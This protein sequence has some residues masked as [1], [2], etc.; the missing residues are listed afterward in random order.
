MVPLSDI[1]TSNA[2]LKSL[3][4]GLVAVFVGGTSGIGL[5]TARELVRNTTSPHIYLVGRNQDEASKI[6]QELKS[7]NASSQVDF[8]QKDVSLLKN[9][10]EVCKEILSK[11]KH[12][13]LL[14]MTCGYYTLKGRED[15]TEGL[16]RKFALHYYARARFINQLQ[17]LL[18]TA[19]AS[20]TLSRVVAV[21]DPQ[22]GLRMSM[23]FSDLSLKSHF[24]L[25]NCAV[26]AGTMTNLL[27]S[28][29]AS[30]NSGT[31]YVHAF[32]YVVDT[33]VGRDA[34]GPLASVMKPLLKVVLKP[35]T[36]EQKESGERHLYALTS[37]TFPPK[38]TG[39]N[40]EGIAVGGDGVKGSGSYLLN[41]NSDVLPDTKHAK[42]MRED[43]AETKVWEHTEEVLKKICEEGGKY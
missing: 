23:N 31:S 32:P 21:L 34:W 42:S 1:R 18:T 26:H 11:E 14:F 13:N 2:A 22:P 28:R 37:P 25:K 6:I 17:P 35:V 20:S 39:G 36:V 19:A 15:T 24:S 27:F 12:V 10:D 41:W 5:F 40:T 38:A 7:I 29:L 8:I 30:M 33:G 16:D 43:G 3:P 9:V 4:S